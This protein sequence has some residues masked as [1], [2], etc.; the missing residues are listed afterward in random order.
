MAARKPTPP[1]TLADVARSGDRLATLEAMRDQLAD[2]MTV[3]N[4]NVVAQIAARLQAVLND[5]AA[6]PTEV[7]VSTAD[8]LARKRADR[9]AAAAGGAPAAEQA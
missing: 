9:I 1:R 6:I 8:D 5:I 3:A 4:E 2:Q 7:E